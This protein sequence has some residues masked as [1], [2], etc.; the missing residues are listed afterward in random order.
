MGNDET[1]TEPIIK[2]NANT[3]DPTTIQKANMD[4]KEGYYTM[5]FLQEADRARYGKIL[6]EMDNGFVK[7]MDSYTKTVLVAYSLIKKTTVSSGLKP[8]PVKG[9]GLP[10]QVFLLERSKTRATSSVMIVG[11]WYT[12]PKI[13][14]K[15]RKEL[16][17]TLWKR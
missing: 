5:E 4:A 6:E 1:L 14:Q 17:I 10:L 15:R 8:T 9:M 13:Y 2:G 3:I 12:M 16:L 11:R 7:G